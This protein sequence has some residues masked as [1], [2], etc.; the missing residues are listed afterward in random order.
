VN[1]I[2]WRVSNR[3]F[4]TTAKKF[5]FVVV[6]ILRVACSACESVLS[7]APIF[8]FCAHGVHLVA[9][10][11]VQFWGI[12]A[13]KGG[14]VGQFWGHVA[15]NPLAAAAPPRAARSPPIAKLTPVPVSPLDVDSRA[16]RAGFDGAT[17]VRSRERGFRKCQP[18]VL[19]RSAR[20]AALSECAPCGIGESGRVGSVPHQLRERR[21]CA[22]T[23]CSRSFY[24]PSSLS[25]RRD[26]RR[27]AGGPRRATNGRPRTGGKFLRVFVPILAPGR[28]C[29]APSSRSRHPRGLVC[30]ASVMSLYVST[31]S[32]YQSMREYM[33]SSST[34]KLA[35]VQNS[36]A[37]SLW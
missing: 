13:Q 37:G 7:R 28:T 6:A 16:R 36:R 25:G 2:D 26:Q 1:E 4:V 15:Q 30:S 18:A 11:A 35:D 23:P 17:C 31:S 22:S 20:T 14:W 3:I 5:P 32:T 19:L 33:T 8:Y 29:T 27:G 21:C 24:L 34:S 12:L 10:L 9:V